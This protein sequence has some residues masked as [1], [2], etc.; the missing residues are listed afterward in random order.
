MDK[1]YIKVRSLSDFIVSFIVLAVGIIGLLLPFSET[2]NLFGGCVTAVG[3]LVL[4]LL[5]TNYKDVK[6]GELLKKKTLYFNVEDKERVLEMVSN[7]QIYDSNLQ[8][9][10]ES[11]MLVIY[12]NANNV[13]MQLYEYVPYAFVPYSRKFTY[14][15]ELVNNML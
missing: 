4:V 2:L 3:V 6:S 10:G 1:N 5:K 15:R 7:P 9:K 8:G 11:L 13:Y 14:N 12:Y